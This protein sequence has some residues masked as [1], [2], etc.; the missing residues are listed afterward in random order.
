MKTNISSEL[1]EI[2]DYIADT[3]VTQYPTDNITADYFMYAILRNDKSGA[4]KLLAEQ[5]QKNDIRDITKYYEEKLKLYVKSNEGKPKFDKI[6]DVCME[7][8]SASHSNNNLTTIDFMTALLYIDVSVLEELERHG[9]IYSKYKEDVKQTTTD[10]SKPSKNAVVLTKNFAGKKQPSPSSLVKQLSSGQDILNLN[11]VA[12]V[13]KIHEFIGRKDT[14]TE[15]F[16]ILKKKTGNNVVIVGE[17]GVGKTAFVENIANLL[18][19]RD[20]NHEFEDYILYKVDMMGVVSNAMYRGVVDNRIKTIVNDAERLGKCILFIDDFDMLVANKERWNDIDILSTLSKIL[21]SSVPCI[22]VSSN[23]MFTKNMLPNKHFMRFIQKI[24]F[25]EATAEETIDIM[26]H[27]KE[28]IEI[29][30]NI[31]IPVDIVEKA[32]NLCQRY[33]TDMHFPFKVMDVLD[34]ACAKQILSSSSKDETLESL[35]NELEDAKRTKDN[36]EVFTPNIDYDILDQHNRAIVAIQQRIQRHKTQSKLSTSTQ[37]LDMTHVQNVIER[38]TGVPT[39]DLRTNDREVLRHFDTKLKKYIINQDTAIDKVCSA[40]KRQRLGFGRKNKPSTFMFL[41]QSGTGKTL[42]SKKIA[43]E[44]FGDENKLVRLDMS[45]YSDRISVNKLYGSAAGYVG[46]EEGGI[47]T[48]AIKRHKHCVL[49]LDEI[50][51]ANDEVFNV[52]LQIFEDGRLTDNKGN[53]VD[54]SKV[55]IIM[56]SNI[57]MSDAVERGSAIGFTQTSST[58]FTDSIINKALKRKFKPEFLNRIDEIIRFNSLNE[59]NIKDIIRLELNRVKDQ[60][61]D[62]GYVFDDSLFDT[63]VVDYIYKESDSKPEYGA[64]PALRSVQRL[65]ENKII[66]LLIEN[67]ITEGHVFTKSEVFDKLFIK[68]A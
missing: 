48:E 50:E 9:F 51:K 53:V 8:A 40:I 33:I 21:E 59:D 3:V 13:G 67:D 37:E 52:F 22:L 12:N 46:Y 25:K 54:F 7:K 18:V 35:Y 4:H 66:D 44:I 11:N 61:V 43:T 17:S 30:H 55:I 32:T 41:G 64:R 14:Y 58:N 15:V 31:T 47:L 2:F 45:E 42:L 49:L 24:N 39:V 65:V 57:G 29:F 10:K 19:S 60:V 28:F 63:E 16:N 20:V 1:K 68:E 6:F 36:Y 62:N 56:T 27:A 34:E 5:F 26:K 23:R 38:R